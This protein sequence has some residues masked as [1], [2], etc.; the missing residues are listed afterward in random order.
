VAD[1]VVIEVDSLVKEYGEN[2]AVKGISFEVR[3]GEV[4]G[5]LGENGAGKTTTL[6]MIEG[7]RVPTSGDTHVFGLDSVKQIN[8]IKERIGVQLQA[9]AYFNNLTLVEILDLFGGFYQKRL[10]PM[11]LLR[12]VDLE[13]K[14]NSR[15]RQLSGGMQQRFS[16]VA[17]L[18]NDPELVFFDEP[19]TGLDPLARRNIWKLVRTVQD[20][21]KTVVL[22]THYMEEAE[23]LCSRVGIMRKGELIALDTTAALVMRLPNPIRVDFRPSGDLTDAQSSTL[24]AIGELKISD[25]SEGEYTLYLKNRDFL[26]KAL[27]EFDGIDTDRLNVGTANLEDVFVQLTGETIENSDAVDHE[28]AGRRRGS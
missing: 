27:R 5:L 20:Q 16:I 14:A 12:M 22:T 9:S 15:V 25:K 1:D 23:S 11:E 2:R 17:S 13:E 26:R 10:D 4:F 3:R 19:T 6:E 24:G 7:L 21:G 18:V 28:A 8:E